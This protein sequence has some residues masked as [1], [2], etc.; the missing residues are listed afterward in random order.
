MRDRRSGEA[1]AAANFAEA[2]AE[3]EEAATL[4]ANS[5]EGLRHIVDR[6]EART[7]EATELRV[8]LEITEEAESTVR[9]E[10]AEERRR[11]EEAEA[12]ARGPAA[13]APGPQG[14]PRIHPKPRPCRGGG[15][16]LDP[17]RRSG[18]LAAAGGVELVAQTDG[19]VTAV[20]ER[21]EQLAERP[22]KAEQARD[23]LR[24][25]KRSLKEAGRPGPERPLARLERLARPLPEADRI[26]RFIG[27]AVGSARA[28]NGRGNGGADVSRSRPAIEGEI[29]TPRGTLDH[30]VT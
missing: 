10:L 20:Q 1:L 11:R 30:G 27:S 18:G 24:D 3:T 12:G 2:S 19:E 23:L 8:R 17:R 13:G 14:G 25:L 21:R 22:R 26:R 7:A 5:G 9:A 4:Y 15:P 29:P 16:H 6:L 28:G